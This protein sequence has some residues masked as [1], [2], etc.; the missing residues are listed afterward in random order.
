MQSE[1]EGLP[2]WRWEEA[3]WGQLPVHVRC[4]SAAVKGSLIYIFGGYLNETSCSSTLFIADVGASYNFVLRNLTPDFNFLSESD[5]LCAKGN[6]RT[7]LRALVS[8]SRFCGRRYV[9]HW[10][11]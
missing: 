11:S 3:V 1:E 8:Y 6:G 4:H 10:G 2:K 7:P 9:R 5:G